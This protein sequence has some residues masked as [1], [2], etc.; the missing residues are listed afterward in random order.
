[1]LRRKGGHQFGHGREGRVTVT[2]AVAL[3]LIALMGLV[4]AVRRMPD[5]MQSMPLTRSDI[6]LGA[7]VAA[8]VV[9]VESGEVLYAQHPEQ[10]IPPASLAKLMTVLL[11]V[12]AVES[13]QASMLDFVTVS[14]HAASMGGSQVWLGSGERYTLGQLLESVM[15]ASA[16]DSAVAVAEYLAGSERQFVTLMTKRVNELGMRNT[17][18]VNASGLPAKQGE[19][20]GYTTASDMARLALEALGHP[21]IL[22]WSS[23]Q[24]KAFRDYPLF[25]MNNTNPLLGMYPGC[26]GLKTGHTEAA[27]YHLIATAR[28]GGV[29]LVAVIMHAGTEEARATGCARLLDYG[30]AAWRAANMSRSTAEPTLRRPR[31]R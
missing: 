29:R 22:K 31:V 26:D 3:T 5:P 8:V 30:F 27:G 15:I 21:A 25:I 19:S 12:E 13:G 24:S 7:A 17:R 1:M 20:D 4:G 23:T 9:E 14:A 11:A 28:A 18:F 10:R 16:N 6:G 2:V